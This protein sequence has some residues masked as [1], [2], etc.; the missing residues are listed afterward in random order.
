MNSEVKRV[1]MHIPK[2]LWRWLD[3][4]VGKNQIKGPQGNLSKTQVVRD[5]LEKLKAEVEK[6]QAK[7]KDQIFKR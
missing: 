2:Y 6:E 4:Y 7:Q 1:S 5:L 3:K